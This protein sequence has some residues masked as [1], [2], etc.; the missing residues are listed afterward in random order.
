MS[1]SCQYHQYLVRPIG[2]FALLLA[3]AVAIAQTANDFPKTYSDIDYSQKI[4]SLRN[5]YGQKIS[6]QNAEQMELATL[7]AV[8][9][10]PLLQNRKIKVIIRK[11]KGAPVEASFSPFNFIKP[12]KSKIYK[13]IIHENSFMERLGLNKQIA[14]LGHEMAHFIQYEERGYFGTLFGLLRYVSSD[15]YRITFEK[16]AD[17]VAIDH[18]LGPLMFDFSFYTSKEEIKIYMDEKGYGY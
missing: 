12:R 10:Y 6:Y 3:S 17:K 14:A 5:L 1:I 2:L 13:I 8:S 4:D 9:H 16:K 7:L 11:V 15:K 18:G